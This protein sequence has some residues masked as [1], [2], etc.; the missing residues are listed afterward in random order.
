MFSELR[1]TSYTPILLTSTWFGQEKWTIAFFSMA[2][3][4]QSQSL[5]LSCF[6]ITMAVGHDINFFFCLQNHIERSPIFLAIAWSIKY[7]DCRRITCSLLLYVNSPPQI[8]RQPNHT[9]TSSI[10][11]VQKC[12]ADAQWIILLYHHFCFH[13]KELLK[14]NQVDVGPE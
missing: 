4:N 2:H 12:L 3:T 5:S 13:K 1:L 14:A 10:S 6:P 9:R 8:G 7:P 11:N